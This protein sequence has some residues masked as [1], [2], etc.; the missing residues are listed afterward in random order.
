MEE[1]HLLQLMVFVA[2]EEDILL[3]LQLMLVVVEEDI[4]LQFQLMVFVA[5]EEDTT[6]LP[7]LGVVVVVC[8]MHLEHLLRLHL[9]LVECQL[10]W[11]RS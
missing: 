5:V 3:Q 6:Q 9:Q 8:L 2:V 11:V 1:E 4:L 10:V 7:Q